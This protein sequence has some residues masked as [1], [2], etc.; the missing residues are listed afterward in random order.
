MRTAILGVGRMGRRHAQVVRKLDLTLAGVYDVNTESLKLAQEELGLTSDRLF[1]DL[2][3]LYDKARPECL[4]IATTADS[5]CQLTCVAAERGVKHILV[6][7]PMAVSLDEC[8]RMVEVC[9]RFGTY[10]AVNHQMRFMEQYVE[11]K[12]LFDSPAYGGLGSMSVIAGNCGFAMNGSHYFEAFRFITGEYPVEAS[13]WFSSGTVANPRGPQFE[14]RAGSIRATTA[15]GKRLH[16]EI[17]SDQGHGARVVYAGRFGMVTVNEV[18]GEIQTS[19][20]EDQY[21]ELPTTRYAMPATDGTRM[22]KAAEVI[23]TSAAVLSALLKGENSV[24]GE[25]GR[26]VVEL[27]AAA[28]QSAERGGAPVRLDAILDRARRFPWA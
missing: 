19:V 17:G 25:D 5:H 8:D 27:L 12:R 3:A 10:L 7:K 11:P 20:R 26:R 21:R 24:T 2:D 1:A 22:I 4:I 18:T 15:S 6:E 14:D 16:M 23:D 13:A 9:K 28:Y